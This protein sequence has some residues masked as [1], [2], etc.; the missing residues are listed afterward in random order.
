MRKESFS[1]KCFNVF[2]VVFMLGLIVVMVFPYLNILAK[3]LNDA[4]DTERGGVLFWP[5]VLTF[6]NFE[7]IFRADGFLRK[8]LERRALLLSGLPKNQAAGVGAE[9]LY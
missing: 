6:H 9:G 8:P 2:N 3:A 1:R 5:R 7:S 4:Q